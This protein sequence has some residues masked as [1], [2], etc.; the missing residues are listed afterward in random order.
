M[1]KSPESSV[2]FENSS[3]SVD[4]VKLI[5]LSPEL[6]V[7]VSVSANPSLPLP[8]ERKCISSWHPPVRPAG[9]GGICGRS[10]T[11]HENSGK[12]IYHPSD[13][14]RMF[15]LAQASG[16]ASIDIEVF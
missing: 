4:M 3:V 1:S 15:P 10:V 8:V 7:L 2:A 16:D 14:I 6:I 11:G 9:V 13:S 12:S 5:P